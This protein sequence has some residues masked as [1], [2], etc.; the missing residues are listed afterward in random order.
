MKFREI[1]GAI[2]SC[3]L[4]RGR[5]VWW[6]PKKSV[7]FQNREGFISE[8]VIYSKNRSV[9]PETVQYNRLIIL[10]GCSQIWVSLYIRTRNR[11]LFVRLLWEVLLRRAEQSE[12]VDANSIDITLLHM[13]SLTTE[14]TTDMAWI[15]YWTK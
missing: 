9:V 12:E 2:C 7:H 15:N 13:T 1:G 11:Q 14:L 4:C 8:G 6:G 5:N 3:S 10:E